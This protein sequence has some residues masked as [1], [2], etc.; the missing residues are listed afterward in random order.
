MDQLRDNTPQTLQNTC[1]GRLRYIAMSGLRAARRRNKPTGAA[2]SAS[3]AS[4]NTNSHSSSSSAAGNASAAVPPA[5]AGR[6]RAASS[7]S[8]TPVSSGSVSGPQNDVVRTVPSLA[9]VTPRGG[10]DRLTAVSS[11]P[12][13]VRRGAGPTTARF[14]DQHPALDNVFVEVFGAEALADHR[15]SPTTRAAK[16]ARFA[17]QKLAKKEGKAKKKLHM[18]HGGDKPC[19]L[20][21]VLRTP[22][23]SCVLQR[24]VSK[25]GTPVFSDFVRAHADSSARCFVRE[26]ERERQGQKAVAVAGYCGIR[27]TTSG[28]HRRNSCR[29]PIC[30]ADREQRVSLSRHQSEGSSAPSEKGRRF[31]ES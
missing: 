15:R 19:T 18:R 9:L 8:S 6:A 13:T 26:Q 14:L 16:S 2:S 7:G 28:L 20:L 31:H 10:T 1:N 23:S 4:S 5:S 12:D 17:V 11:V 25:S 29:V 3:T 22:D 21:F 24:V 27:R 30:S